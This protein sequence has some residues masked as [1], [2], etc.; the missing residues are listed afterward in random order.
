MEQSN[1]GETHE[2]VQEDKTGN[3]TIKQDK[4]ETMTV[5]CNNVK[6]KNQAGVLEDS[7]KPHTSTS[8][9]YFTLRNLV[10]Q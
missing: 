10:S 9:S 6:K 8:T 4:Q 7:S 3:F 5:K 2:Q 1:T